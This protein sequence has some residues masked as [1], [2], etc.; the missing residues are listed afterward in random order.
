MSPL[1]SIASNGSK[2]KAGSREE[3]VLHPTLAGCTTG[4]PPE[5]CS[6][7]Q[8]V[9]LPLVSLLCQLLWSLSQQEQGHCP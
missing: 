5:S 6:A 7:T 2:G 9:S 4:V 3:E 8:C 1:P